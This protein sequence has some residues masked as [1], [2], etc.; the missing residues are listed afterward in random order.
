M[1]DY[2]HSASFPAPLCRR[3]AAEVVASGI[4]GVDVLEIWPD[5]GSLMRVAVL[6]VLAGLYVP[7]L[8]DTRGP[9][10][11]QMQAG[12]FFRNLALLGAS[13]AM[14]GFFVAAGESPRFTIT[15]LCSIRRS[16]TSA[17]IIPASVG[18]LL[19]P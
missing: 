4:F 3:L 15:A 16:E 9:E 13:L 6:V 1:G 11:R 19:R 2:A 10:Q 12:N 7:S 8:L 18:F 14:L 17:R 5:L